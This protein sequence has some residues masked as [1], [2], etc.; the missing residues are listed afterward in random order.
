M[1]T[2]I[3]Q[4]QLEAELTAAEE[5]LNTKLNISVDAI[6]K[7]KG[8]FPFA[9]LAEATT[10]YNTQ[11]GLGQT[12]DDLVLPYIED[13][14]EYRKWDNNE[15]SKTVF[16]KKYSSDIPVEGGS[17]PLSVGGAFTEFAKKADKTE[18][19]T[20]LNKSTTGE[21][22]VLDD[23][24]SF[25]FTDGDGNVFGEIAVEGTKSLNFQVIDPI[26]KEVFATINKNWITDLLDKFNDTNIE[27]IRIAS[28]T[29]GFYF[30]DSLG[31]LMA[32]INSEGLQSIKFLDKNGDEIGTP[33]KKLE[34]EFVVS[35]GDSHAT[36]WLDS[37]C[38]YTGASWSSDLQT[39]IRNNQ[40]NYE[41]YGKLQGIAQALK[42]YL[43]DNP[44]IVVDRIF[45]ENVH[46]SVGNGTIN[47][48]AEFFDNVETY[49]TT[50][51]SWQNLIDNRGIDKP[52]FIDSLTPTLK[53][54]LKFNYNTSKTT[55][56]FS[57]AGVLNA[58]TITLTIDGNAFPITVTNGMTLIEAV[59]LLNDWNFDTYLTDWGNAS[60]KGQTR[61]DGT[62]VLNYDGS[63]TAVLPTIDFNDGGTGMVLDSSVLGTTTSSFYDYF[64]SVDLSE[65]QDYTLW[66]ASNG[67]HFY[68]RV[69][70]L[71]GYLQETFPEIKIAIWAVQWLS[72]SDVP[73][74]PNSFQKET[75]VGSGEYIIDI[76]AYFND[77]SVANY[78]LAKKGFKEIA[79]RYNVPY[80][81]VD[82]NCGITIHNMF[83]GGYYAANNLHPLPK[84]Y[85]AWGETL[86]KLIEK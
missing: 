36:A 56:Q 85:T 41:G 24:K 83:S 66:V 84:G 19:N 17:E 2:A 33:P 72:V 20:K 60:T 22:K 68:R 38:E 37:F 21:A 7:E 51:G 61:T 40:Y 52:A 3:N 45:I 12:I 4:A 25:K 55:I 58:G 47:D 10:Y 43:I 69:K 35:L 14:F 44:T 50:Y 34:G 67:T 82:S 31:N 1:S 81:D 18:V 65:W 28:N 11:I 79:E 64:A 9:T 15:V 26:T 78:M 13:T 42:Q 48:V 16:V 76:D 73:T 6:R 70:G 8:Y 71:M 27:D 63:A 5:R 77:P 53:T 49:G 39:Y 80:Y 74:D 46:Y 57:S 32:K 23:S 30:V 75:S 54:A 62:I 59:T 86:G 29:E